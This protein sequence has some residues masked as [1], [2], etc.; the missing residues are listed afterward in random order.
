MSEDRQSQELHLVFGAEL[1]DLRT[2]RIRDLSQ[3][4]F[5]GI[6]GDAASARSA[7]RSK[8]Q[9]SVDSAHIRYFIAPLHEF[10]DSE[11]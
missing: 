9:E 4:D 1:S 7:W 8:S 11:Y 6:F 2:H 3:I 10:L 5:V